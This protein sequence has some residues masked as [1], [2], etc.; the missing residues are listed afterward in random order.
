ME[1]GPTPLRK[2]CH[3]AGAGVSDWD[4]VKLVLKSLEKI[5][6]VDSAAATGRHCCHPGEGA[7]LQ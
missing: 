1:E 7:S 3:L 2:E 5:C 6:K 4:T